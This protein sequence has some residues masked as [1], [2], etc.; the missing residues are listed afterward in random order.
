MATFVL[1]PGA[2]HGSWTFE[3]VSPLLEQAGLTVHAPT[4]TGLRPDDDHTT[5]ANA[6][7][8]THAFDVIDLLERAQITDAILVG[9]SYGGMVITAAADRASNRVSHLIYLDAYVPRHGDSCWSL[10]TENYRQSFIN[11]ATDTGHAV[12]PPFRVPHG[13]DPRR[14]PHPLASLVQTVQ[15]TGAIDL[16]PKRDYIYCSGWENDTPFAALRAR[17]QADPSWHT[18]DI[19]TAHNAMRESPTTLAELLINIS[20][21]N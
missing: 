14:R 7:L 20:T 21:D 2:W 3:T 19:P 10:T 4:L 6:N 8:D 1:V 18:H 11:G 15:L 13:G 9:H 5:I 12:R 16:I 17:L